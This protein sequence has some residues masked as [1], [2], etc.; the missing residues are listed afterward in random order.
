MPDDVRA[1]FDREWATTQEEF[2]KLWEQATQ[3]AIAD[4]KAGGAQFSEVDSEAF[5]AVLEPTRRGVTDQR[6]PA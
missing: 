5:R 1:I 6:R 4:A 3:D 2:T